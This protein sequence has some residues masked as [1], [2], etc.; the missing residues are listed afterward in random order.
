[1]ASSCRNW[2]VGPFSADSA[3]WHHGNFSRVQKANGISWKQTFHPLVKYLAKVSLHFLWT[4][5]TKKKHSCRNTWNSLQ[6]SCMQ[7]MLTPQ[8][9]AASMILPILLW[10]ASLCSFKLAVV[11]KTILL[12]IPAIRTTRGVLNSSSGALNLYPWISKSFFSERLLASAA[13]SRGLRKTNFWFGKFEIPKKKKNAKVKFQKW[14]YKRNYSLKF[15]SVE[16]PLDFLKFSLR[17]VFFEDFLQ[18]FGVTQVRHGYKLNVCRASLLLRFKMPVVVV[19]VDVF[20]LRPNC[21]VKWT[22]PQ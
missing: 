4:E 10:I 22:V 8:W 14:N 13:I 11:G 1:M 2:V 19:V 6:S 20:I 17:Y 5:F 12:W 9:C 16:Y 21:S 15:S 7:T 18:T 3:N